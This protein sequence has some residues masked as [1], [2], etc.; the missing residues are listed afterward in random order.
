MR[1]SLFNPQ[2]SDRVEHQK[3]IL[4]S[5]TGIANLNESK[6][7]WATNLYNAMRQ[8][9]WIQSVVGMSP[10]TATIKYLT[11]AEMEA[12]LDSLGFLIALDSF[13]VANLPNIMHYISAPNVRLCIAEQVAQEALHTQA[14]QYIAEETLT[15]TQRKSIYERWKKT[16]LLAKRISFLSEIG[17]AFIESPNIENFVRVAAANFALEGI[18]FYQGFNYYD[19]L[20]S[21]KKL[22]ST[23]KQ[24]T[25]IRRDEITHVTLFRNILV[26]VRDE[27]PDIDVNGIV[28]DVIKQAVAQENEWGQTIYGDRILGINPTTITEYCNYLGNLRLG[29]LDIA[30]AFPESKNPYK[31]L[32]AMQSVDGKEKKENFF[33]GAVTGYDRSETLGG[34]EYF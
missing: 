11:E 16:P 23:Q 22:V 34:F 25:Y 33:E 15:K 32:T 20:S 19:Q 31:H 18:F 5:G 24:I 21:R 9:F 14:Y 17:L 10:D 2:G 1:V 30:P 8:N 29:Q 27:Q 26:S 28:L 13:A 6:Y 4:G 7:T 3:M 12:H